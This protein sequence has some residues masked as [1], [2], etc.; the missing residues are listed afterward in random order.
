M[1]VVPQDMSISI[2]YNQTICEAMMSAFLDVFFMFLAFVI[3][4]IGFA[5]LIATTGISPSNA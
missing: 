5:F 1:A 3:V 4:G 2:R